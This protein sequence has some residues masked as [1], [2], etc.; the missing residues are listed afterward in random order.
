MA[1]EALIR[2]VL[3]PVLN[4]YPDGGL[5]EQEPALPYATYLRA[6]GRVVTTVG[7][8]AVPDLQHAHVQINVWAETALEASRLMRE[9]DK[10]IRQT[11]AFDGDPLAA[12]ASLPSDDDSL[13][14]T[15]DFSI[16]FKD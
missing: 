1:L 6:G 8:E 16:W 9:V 12:P 7:K 14:L 15:Q 4:A 13:G 11:T 5:P 3:L 10:A 2:T